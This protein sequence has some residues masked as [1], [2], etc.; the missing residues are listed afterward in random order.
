MSASLLMAKLDDVVRSIV[1]ETAQLPDAPLAD[2]QPLYSVGLDSLDLAN[3]AVEIENQLGVRLSGAELD[4]PANQ[5]TVNYLI[6][7]VLA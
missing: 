5:M 2:D 4:V 3:I 1:R 7:K 6:E